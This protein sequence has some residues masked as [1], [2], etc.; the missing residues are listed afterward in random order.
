[1][2]TCKLCGGMTDINFIVAGDVLPVCEGCVNEIVLQYMRSKN[3][4]FCA[5]SSEESASNSA[6][7]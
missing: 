7:V 3:L 4:I 6:G 5:P 2:G 1:M